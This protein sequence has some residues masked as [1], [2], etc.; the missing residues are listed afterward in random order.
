MKKNQED[1]N[2]PLLKKYIPFR[3][4][5]TEEQ[6]TAGIARYKQLIYENRRRASEVKTTA[7]RDLVH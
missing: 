6:M 4:I 5:L 7:E 3:G 1:T 2:R